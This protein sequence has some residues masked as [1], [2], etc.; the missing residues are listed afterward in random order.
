MA[1]GPFDLVELRSASS[2]DWAVADT[3]RI[4]VE[5]PS[6]PVALAAS[7]LAVAFAS[8]SCLLVVAHTFVVLV[9]CTSYWAA[10]LRLVAS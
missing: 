3:C 2:F 8:C 7:Y 1:V 5:A 4:V 6:F 10:S 9:G